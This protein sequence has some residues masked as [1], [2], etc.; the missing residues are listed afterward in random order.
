MLKRLLITV[1]AVALAG[2]LILG[3]GLGMERLGDWTDAHPE[4]RLIAWSAWNIGVIVVAVLVTRRW[5]RYRRARA[6]KS[7]TPAV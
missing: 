5:M 6:A 7:G 2:A 3:L 1:G 4:Y